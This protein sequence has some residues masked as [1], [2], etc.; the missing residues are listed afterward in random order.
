MIVLALALGVLAASLLPAQARRIEVSPDSLTLAYGDTVR[1]RPTVVASGGAVTATVTYSSADTTIFAV[2]SGLVTAKAKAGCAALRVMSGTYI[3]RQVAVCVRAPVVTPPPDT[4]T[5]PPDTTPPPSGAL[6]FASDWSRGDVL[7]GGTWDYIACQSAPQASAVVDGATVGWTKTPKVVRFRQLGESVC[8]MLV[9]SNVLPAST[10][11][12]GRLYFRND[13]VGSIHNHV[14]TYNPGFGT[15]IQLSFWNRRGTSAG[16][17]LFLRTYS[18]S[19]P[20][21]L[22]NVRGPQ[23]TAAAKF[24]NGQWFRYEWHLEYVSADRVRIWPR[25]YDLA[26]TLLADASTTYRNDAAATASQSL[27]AYYAGGGTFRIDPVLGRT[28]GLGNEGP[29]TSTSTG[30][31]WYHADV[32]LSLTGWIGR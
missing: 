13:E 3:R 29:A 17:E 22:W 25:V 15:P 16:M 24:A 5:P 18:N 20:T 28:I 30:G 12:W 27:A 9:K 4:V 10:S 21:D 2:R 8:A 6:L 23:G 32:A 26:G 11:H 7:D 31:Y 14:A 1:V 19:Y